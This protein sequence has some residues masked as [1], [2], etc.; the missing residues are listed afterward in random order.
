MK[1]FSQNQL[2]IATVV[3]FICLS[4]PVSI[5]AIWIYV[6]DIEL[7]QA[8]QVSIFNNYFPD[9]LHGRWDTTIL[10]I[11]LC[12]AAIILSSLSLES[13]SKLWKAF[14]LVIVIISSLL[15]LLN[16]FSMM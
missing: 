16:L 4:V 10:S 15:F 5:F 2:K 7:S 13:K 8:E 14:S 11:V 12:I 9:F 1:R 3:S 6:I